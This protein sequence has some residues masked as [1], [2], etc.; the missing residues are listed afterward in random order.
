M[1]GGVGGVFRFFGWVM[2]MVGFC[3]CERLGI[4]GG[5]VCLVWMILFFWLLVILLVNMLVLLVFLFFVLVGL[6]C[7]F[8]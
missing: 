2:L 8:V 7:W 3:G 5:V 4:V 1:V 6:F